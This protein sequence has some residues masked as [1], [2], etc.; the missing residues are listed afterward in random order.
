MSKK[1][2]SILFYGELL[3]FIWKKY[4]DHPTKI[5]MKFIDAHQFNGSWFIRENERFMIS[6]KS[7]GNP[8]PRLNQT[9]SH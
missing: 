3:P 9:V 8:R 4:L 6:C 1:M 7:D 2:N 5:S